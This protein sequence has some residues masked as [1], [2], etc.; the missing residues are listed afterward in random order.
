MLYLSNTSMRMSTVDVI[1][2]RH[3]GRTCWDRAVGESFDAY[4][5][6]FLKR[7]F[8][9][10]T[11]EYRVMPWNARG[12]LAPVVW[13]LKSEHLL[14]PDCIQVGWTSSLCASELIPSRRSSYARKPN[15]RTPRKES[16]LLHDRIAR[17]DQPPVEHVIYLYMLY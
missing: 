10:T 12:F 2:E 16:E 17:L 5:L 14:G 15:S 3:D 6:L 1:R 13:R 11:S 7:H 8:V 9:I 4:L